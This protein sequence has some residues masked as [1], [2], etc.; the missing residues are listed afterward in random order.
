MC[1]VVLETVEVLVPFVADI[2]FVWFLLFHPNC[3]GI[4]LIV[5]RIQ[6]GER[7]VSVFLEPL[8]LMSVCFMVLE[9]VGIAVGFICTG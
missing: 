1:L 4:W 2:A 7:S 3:A 8:V 5:V 6:N 9:S